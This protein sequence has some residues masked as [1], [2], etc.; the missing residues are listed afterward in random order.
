MVD[1]RLLRRF[2]WLLAAVSL[3]FALTLVLGAFAIM[4]VDP[5]V[6]LAALVTVVLV[7][8]VGVLTFARSTGQGLDVV[9]E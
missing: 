7:L 6:G 1:D 3:W 2:D 5:G 9:A 8:V 4:A